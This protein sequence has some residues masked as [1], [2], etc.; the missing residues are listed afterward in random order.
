MSQVTQLRRAMLCSAGLR[1]HAQML[2]IAVHHADKQHACMQAQPAVFTAASAALIPSAWPQ[3]WRTG[4]RAAGD[5]MPAFWLRGIVAGEVAPG[6][7]LPTGIF[8]LA[9]ARPKEFL[10]N[11]IMN[12]SMGALVPLWKDNLYTAAG[13][14]SANPHACIP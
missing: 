9:G 14:L 7:M 10:L 5:S 13:L 6:A 4:D 2:L 11:W 8:W 12:P 3:T 1:Y